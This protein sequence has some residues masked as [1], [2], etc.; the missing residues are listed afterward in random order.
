MGRMLTIQVNRRETARSCFERFLMTKR[1]NG[2]QMVTITTYSQQFHAISKHLDI[3]KEMD[4]MTVQDLQKMVISMQDAGL[5][6]NTI[7]SYTITLKAFL[8]WCNDEGIT[9]LNMKR[10]KGVETIKETYSIDELTML[11]KKPNMKDCTFSEYRNWVIENFLINS[12]SRAA[13]VRNIQNRDVDIYNRVIYARHTK[14]KKSLVIPLCSKMVNILIEYMN[15]RGG[16]IDDYL[17]PNIYGEQMTANSFKKT[18]EYYNR[19]RG[20]EKTSIH[21]FRHTF[22]KLYLL[23][24][25]GNALMLQKLLGHSTLDMTKLYCSIFDADLTR[26]FDE[27]SPL[28]KL[29]TDRERMKMPQGK[30]RQNK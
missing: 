16:K 15:I 2:V 30:T 21:L 14:N 7:R 10:Y 26:D 9:D 13:T 24:C 11:L 17:F 27:F 18:I 12:G 23:D 1:S 22:A 6:P 8:S 20:V 25:G 4:E 3:D 29:T 28:S 19:K 5:S